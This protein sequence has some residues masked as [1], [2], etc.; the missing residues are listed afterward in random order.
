MD[1]LGSNHKLDL[2]RLLVEVGAV[3]ANDSRAQRG[4]QLEINSLERGSRSLK[5][6][7]AKANDD[8]DDDWD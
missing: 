4:Q 3:N 6:V 2:Q 8:D 1:F 7:K 5:S